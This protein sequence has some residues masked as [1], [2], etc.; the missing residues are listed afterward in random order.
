MTEFRRVTEEFW[1]S[2]QI[3]PT[4][5]EEAR[6]RGFALI[7]NNR[8]DDESPGQPRD[9][10]IAAAVAAA[11][12]AYRAIPVTPGGF[13]RGHVDAMTKALQEAGGPVLAFC[14]SGTRSTLLWALAEAGRGRS[15]EA[16]AADAAGAGY[17]IAP[18]RALMERLAPGRD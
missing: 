9:E 13:D 5:V 17:D 10:E 2:P 7:V 6:Q 1:A 12:L 3:E 16:I 14:R 18:V 4:D 8:P 15:V 11:G